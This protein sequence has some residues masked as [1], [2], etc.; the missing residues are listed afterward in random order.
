MGSVSLTLNSPFFMGGTVG[1]IVKLSHIHIPFLHTPAL[2]QTFTG[3]LLPFK[4]GT[5][6]APHCIQT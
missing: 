4:K 5:A 1:Y 3:C 2:Q 6:D